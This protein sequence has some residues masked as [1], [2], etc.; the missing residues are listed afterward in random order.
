M[1]EFLKREVTNGDVCNNV[2]HGGYKESNSERAVRAGG[3][4]RTQS[5]AADKENT[6]CAEDR[7]RQ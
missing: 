7:S 2:S 1:A 5:D 4:D 3:K 6:C